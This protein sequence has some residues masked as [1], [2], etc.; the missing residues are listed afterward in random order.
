[1]LLVAFSVGAR[2]YGVPVDEVITVVPRLPVR[3]IA[4][5]PAWVP[6]VFEYFGAMVPVVDLC[7]LLEARPCRTA[8]ATR[9][10]LV[11]Y[12]IAEGRTRPLGLAAEHMTD[13]VDVDGSAFRDSGVAGEP[14]LGPLAPT[15]GGDLLQRVHVADLLPPETR[16]HLFPGER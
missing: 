2:R 15:G 5:A 12:P 7:A 13:V 10:L 6:G 16:A 11:R 14:W 3:P 9:V 1:M 8:F 4:G